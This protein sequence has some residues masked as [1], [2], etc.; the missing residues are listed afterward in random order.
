MWRRMSDMKTPNVGDKM[1]LASIS[2]GGK[3]EKSA[4][5]IECEVTKVDEHL[6]NVEALGQNYQFTI[7]DWDP[8]SIRPKYRLFPSGEYLDELF[9]IA[10]A[11]TKILLAFNFTEKGRKNFTLAQLQGALRELG[12]DVD[13]V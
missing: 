3:V 12:L 10:S 9:E 8:V 5:R 13:D 7:E 2:F 11:R 4:S 1:I 6:I